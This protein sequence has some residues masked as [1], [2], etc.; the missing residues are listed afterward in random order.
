MNEEPLWQQC[1][2]WLCRMEV[3]PTNHR[4][5][6]PDA[7]CQ[8]L[9]YTLRDGVV[10]CFVA[11][12][13]NPASIEMKNVNLRPQMAQFLCLKNIKAFLK[14]CEEFFQLRETDLF[15]PSML[16]GCTDFGRVLNTLSKLS[17]CQ[18]VKSS[19]PDLQGF[20]AYD[21]TVLGGF[22][23]VLH[24][25]FIHNPFLGSMYKGP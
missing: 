19:R 13:L 15:G 14:S 7:T 20:R 6:W 11:S 3:L 16:Y 1:A 25:Y 18:M 4:I 9:A 21:Q 22:W 17:N 23:A 8:H 12:A 10:L 5:M 24:G 2:D